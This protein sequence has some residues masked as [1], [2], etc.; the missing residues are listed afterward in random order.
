MKKKLFALLFV[1]MVG[2]G[3]L[4][5]NLISGSAAPDSIVDPFIKNFWDREPVLVFDTTGYTLAGPWHRKLSVYT[6]GTASISKYVGFPHAVGDAFFTNVG[7]AAVKELS[8]A[9]LEANAHLLSD[10]PQMVTDTPLTSVTFFAEPAP[11]SKANTYNYFIPNE[12]QLKAHTI[13]NEFIAAW[14]PGF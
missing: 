8:K 14:F 12:K 2:V 5:P 13:I 3:F 7:D 11:V 4:I 9:L 6:D 1:V 10:N